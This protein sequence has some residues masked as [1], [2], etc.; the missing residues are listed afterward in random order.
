MAEALIDV[1]VSPPVLAELFAE[2]KSWTESGGS[3]GHDAFRYEM[4]ARR[5]VAAEYGRPD[6]VEW[7]L[8][9]HADLTAARKA[10]ADALQEEAARHEAQRVAIRQQ[11]QQGKS[12]NP[13]YQLY[14]DTVE[15]P[16]N[17][18]H[19]AEYLIFISSR[20]SEFERLHARTCDMGREEREGRFMTFLR[21]YRDLHLA[22]R[23][24][25]TTDA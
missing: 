15:H 16:E 19:N 10:K 22:R 21:E 25:P 12:E 4:F 17:L 24:R 7:A 6:A 1:E 5:L 20:V 8:A 14:L 3:V 13:R 11:I 9:W 23:L 18:T 2:L